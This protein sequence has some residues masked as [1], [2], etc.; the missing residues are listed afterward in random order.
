MTPTNTITPTYTPTVTPTVA[1]NPIGFDNFV[2]DVVYYDSGNRVYAGGGYSSYD[3]TSANAIISLNING[4]TRDNTFNIGTGFEYSLPFSEPVVRQMAIQSDG[5][6]IAVGQFDSYNGTNVGPHIVRLNTNG[7][8]DNTFNTGSGF[9]SGCASVVIQSDGKILVGGD[10][11]SYNGTNVGPAIVRLNSNG[12]IDNTFNTGTGFVGDTDSVGNEYLQ[13]YTMDIQDDGKIL[14]GGGFI[15]YNGVSRNNVCRLNTNGSLDTTFNPGTGI[16]PAAVIPVTVI[17]QLASGDIMICADMYDYNGNVVYGA[18]RV[19]SDGSYDPGFQNQFTITDIPYDFI[20]TSTGKY[21]FVG[22]VYNYGN[23]YLGGLVM[24][25]TDGTRYSGFYTGE[26]FLAGYPFSVEELP[27]GNFVMV[28]I[29][30]EYNNIPLKE[31]I[32]VLKSDGT[33]I[34]PCDPNCVGCTGY[35]VV[36]TQSD[37]D[38]SED[39]KVYLIYSDCVN[40]YQIIERVYEFSGTYLND[41]CIDNCAGYEPF[42]CVTLDEFDCYENI[43]SSIVPAGDCQPV[44]YECDNCFDMTIT[45]SGIKVFDEIVEL[46][47]DYGNVNVTISVTGA[48][49]IFEV[50]IGNYSNSTGEVFTFTSPNQTITKTFGFLGLGFSTAADIAVYASQSSGNFG[51]VKMNFCVDCPT[52]PACDD[53]PFSE[54]T[55]D[56]YSTA[57]QACDSIYFNPDPTVGDAVL[58]CDCTTYTN[59]SFSTYATGTYFLSYGTDYRQVSVINGNETV[60]ATTSCSTCSEVS[61]TPTPTNTMT[62]TVTPTT[63]FIPSPTP[64]TTITPTVTRTIPTCMAYILGNN[65]FSTTYEYRDC[66]SGELIQVFVAANTT[67]GV[68]CSSTVPT[69]GRYVIL[70]SCNN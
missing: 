33:L 25:N 46:G 19:N 50:F 51:E 61:P 14:C 3:N 2:Q 4:L 60:T 27:N 21:L 5:K 56:L 40:K 26:G 45:N 37:L 70:G 32:A 53:V 59:P 23:D 49:E 22:Y 10:F 42:L 11:S 47:Q 67:Y 12:S 8:I 30:R 57:N 7:T 38:L 48:T 66:S 13:I 65:S 64:T 28:G 69:G 55:S 43:T 16:T 54:I 52:I 35:N 17:K 6:V 9:D 29:M 31:N 68:V 36:I 18:V 62:P 63:G 24:T 58:F 39:G 34:D 1:C 41:V 44:V 20:E 15:S